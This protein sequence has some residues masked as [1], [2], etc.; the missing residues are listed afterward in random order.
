MSLAYLYDGSFDG[1]LSCVFAAYITRR[2]PDELIE[3]DNRQLAFNQQTVQ[4]VT[5]DVQARRVER[6][7]VNKMGSPVLQ[8][9]WMVMLSASPER[10]TVLLRYIRR[11][12]AIGRRIYSDLAHPDVLAV[13]KLYRPVQ[14]ESCAFREFLRFSQ[15]EGSVYYA[16]ISP[17]HQIVSL[18]MPHFVDRFSDQP[19][20]IHDDVHEV[21]GV[22]DTREWYLIGTQGMAIPDI[23]AEELDYRRMWKLFYHT[24]AIQERLNPKCR[25]GLM[26]K[27]YWKNLT[28]MNFAETPKTRRMDEQ[29]KAGGVVPQ[30]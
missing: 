5:D 25:R 23:T 1:L 30:H 6:G 4:I 10:G 17:E 14:R 27:K 19:F 21:A 9:I 2:W 3:Q 26:P 8:K 16:R 13:E 7:I 15:M 11:G 18:L 24:I 12:F 28:E 29:R 20:L 22:Y